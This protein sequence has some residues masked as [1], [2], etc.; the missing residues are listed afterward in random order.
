MIPVRSLREL[1]AN[2]AVRFEIGTHRAKWEPSPIGDRR[3]Q[4]NLTKT[5][6]DGVRTHDVQLEKNR[7]RKRKPRKDN[8]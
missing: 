6:G 8:G 2:D 4:T 7:R 5:A 1:P 3:L